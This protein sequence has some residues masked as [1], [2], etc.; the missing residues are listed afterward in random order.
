MKKIAFLIAAAVLL[1]GCATYDTNGKKVGWCV[2]FPCLWQRPIP[3]QEEGKPDGGAAEKAQA[4][5]KSDAGAS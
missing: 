2:G 1:P 4:G 3:A 5:H